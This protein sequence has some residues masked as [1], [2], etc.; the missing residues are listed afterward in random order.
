MD[1]GYKFKS[2]DIPQVQTNLLIEILAQQQ[3]F[4]STIIEY[5]KATDSEIQ[6]IEDKINAL[7]P[8][9]KEELLQQLYVSFGK[10]PDV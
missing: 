9:K 10:T 5:I 7:T 4:F 1:E 3:A 6:E 8:L 2:E